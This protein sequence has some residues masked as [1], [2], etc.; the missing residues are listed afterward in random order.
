MVDNRKKW[1]PRTQALRSDARTSVASIIGITYHCLDHVM[2]ETKWYT[3]RTLKS[4]SLK[5]NSHE[6][7]TGFINNKDRLPTHHYDNLGYFR[8]GEENSSY[9]NIYFKFQRSSNS[10][11]EGDAAS[12][13]LQ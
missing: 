1:Q 10:K 2:G 5:I 12:R 9:H 7:E 4:F 13:N 8:L 11:L 6:D 3:F